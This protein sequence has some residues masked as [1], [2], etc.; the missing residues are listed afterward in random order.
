[1][2][3]SLYSCSRNARVSHLGAIAHA[4]SHNFSTN[5]CAEAVYKSPGAFKVAIGQ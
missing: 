4:G 5:G 1:M 3:A 2:A